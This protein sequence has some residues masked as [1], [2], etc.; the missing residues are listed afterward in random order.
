MVT[1]T[2]ALREKLLNALTEHEKQLNESPPAWWT[3]DQIDARY[4]R[5]QELRALIAELRAAT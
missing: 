3:D 2:D 4:D 5:Q 1:I